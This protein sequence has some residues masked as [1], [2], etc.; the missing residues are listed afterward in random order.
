MLARD[1]D[2]FC[3][4]A[5]ANIEAE[6]IAKG[7]RK[8]TPYER[9]RTLLMAKCSAGLR[10][11]GESNDKAAVGGLMATARAHIAA[12]GRTL[13]MAAFDGCDSIHIVSTVLPVAIDPDECAGIT[14]RRTTL[15]V[16]H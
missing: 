10:L 16:K 5:A 13:I 2:E 7:T 14:T 9:L 12:D 4:N 6:L 8:F 15:P 1:F 3:A 11:R